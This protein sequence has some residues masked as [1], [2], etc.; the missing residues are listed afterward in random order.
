MHVTVKS[1]IAGIMLS[2]FPLLSAPAVGVGMPMPS[3]SDF[4]SKAY[5]YR[6]GIP[7]PEMQSL[8]ASGMPASRHSGHVS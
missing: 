1:A 6:T 3:K 2:V 8:V 7:E 5:S 4:S